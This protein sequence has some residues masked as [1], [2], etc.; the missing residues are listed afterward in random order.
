LDDALGRLR[1]T[2]RRRYFA[3]GDHAVSSSISSTDTS[4]A[5]FPS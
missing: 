2:I 4:A 3:E 5:Y 1:V